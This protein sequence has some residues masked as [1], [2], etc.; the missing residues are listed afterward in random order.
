MG[1]GEEHAMRCLYLYVPYLRYEVICLKDD[2]LHLA[3]R[4]WCSGVHDCLR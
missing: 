4:A 2:T 3:S 1:G